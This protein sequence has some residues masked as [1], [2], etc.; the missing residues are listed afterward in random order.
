[1]FTQQDVLSGVPVGIR[2]RR[3]LSLITA[4]ANLKLGRNA[5]SGE[6]PIGASATKSLIDSYNWQLSQLEC[7]CPDHLSEPIP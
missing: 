7:D 2:F 1:M 3:R 6:T 5:L 4:S